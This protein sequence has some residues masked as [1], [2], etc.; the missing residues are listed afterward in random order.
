MLYITYT[1]Q[2]TVGYSESW[3]NVLCLAC[4]LL[5]KNN[6][7]TGVGL[8][9]QFPPFRYFPNFSESQKHTLAIE[10]RVHIWQVSPQL[11]CGG[12]CQIW[13]WLKWS[14]RCIYKIEYSAYGEIKERS[15]NNP[16]PWTIESSYLLQMYFNLESRYLDIGFDHL[17]M[18]VAQRV[19]FIS[20]RVALYVFGHATNRKIQEDYVY[21]Q[22]YPKHM[23]H[24]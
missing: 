2:P 6:C 20:M 1:I 17:T 24:V 15:F 16:H 5:R 23:T 21:W 3:T 22:Y 10:Y 14:N 19:A 13:M 12:T 8:L 18:P 11:R 7:E 9:S 4:P